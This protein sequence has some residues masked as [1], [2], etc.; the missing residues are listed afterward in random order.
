MLVSS[1]TVLR[2]YMPNA[3]ISVEGEVP[4]FD[5]LQPYLNAAQIWLGTYV[6]TEKQLSDLDDEAITAQAVRYVCL[7]AFYDATPALDLVLTPTGFGV[8]SNQTIAPAS[9]ERVERFLR[10]VIIQA[11]DALI[12]LNNLLRIDS[13]WQHEMEQGRSYGNTL[14]SWHALAT[15]GLQTDPEG[16]TKLLPE[17]LR[18]ENYVKEHA[19][20]TDLY[21]HFIEPFQRGRYDDADQNAICHAFVRTCMTMLRNY[22]TPSDRKHDEYE[23]MATLVHTIRGSVYADRWE[24]T[25]TAALWSA[26]TYK[27]NKRSGGYWF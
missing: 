18:V 27:N 3:L 23:A 14:C 22:F 16:L 24:Q 11:T 19:L 9:K 7:R 1:D 6:I 25:D 21:D 5:K 13:R 8:V 10:S 15:L 2:R 4:L 26:E 20:S 12:C 17:L